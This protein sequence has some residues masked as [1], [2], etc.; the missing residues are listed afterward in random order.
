M[1]IKNKVTLLVI[2]VLITG[3]FI[4][5]MLNRIIMQNRIEKAFSR[6]NPNRIPAF[7]ERILEPDTDTSSQIRSILAKHAKKIRGIREDYQKKMQKA[8]QSLY[9]ELVPFLTPI[10]RKRF[11]QRLFMPGMPFRSPGRFPD[12]FHTGEAFDKD[13]DFLKKE[14]SLSEEQTAKVREIFSKYR[15]PLWTPRLEFR[16]MKDDKMHE[17]ILQRIEERDKTVKEVLDQ[18]QK[19]LYDKLRKQV[20]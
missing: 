9:N 12:N 16:G 14:L 13:V 8:N 7:Y 11:N 1:N 15:I 6:I 17:D 5:V 2:I 18:R 19:K 20:N 3:I 10:Q 4:G